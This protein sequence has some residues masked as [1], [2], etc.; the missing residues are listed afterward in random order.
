MRQVVRDGHALG[1]FAE[2]TR[3]QRRARRGAAGRGD[4]RDPGG[5]PSCP[6]PSTARRPGGRA[7]SI[8]CRSPGA[9]R[10]ASTGCRRAGG[11]PRG[12]GRAA[13]AGSA[14]S[15][16][17]SW[18]CTRSA[19]RGARRPTLCRHERGAEDELDGTVAI[20]GFPNVG[21]S[22]LVNRLTETRA[23]VVHE[24]PGVTRD[25]KELLADWN[26]VQLPDRRHRW[27]RPGRRGRVRPASRRA[28]ARGDRGGRPRA[29]RRRRA[30][31]ITPGRRGVADILRAPAS[32]CSSSRTRSTTRAATPRRS[33]ST[34]SGSATRCRSRRC[35]AT[36]RAT[37]STRSSSC[38]PAR[39]R[40]PV[41]EEAIRVAILG[42]PNVGKSSLLNAL[43]GEERVIV[44]EVP[45]TTR[46]AIDTVLDRRRRDVRARRHRGPAPQAAAA[47]ASSTTR[48]CAR[49]RRPSVRTC[50]R[51]RRRERGHRRAGPSRRGRGPQGTA[52]RRSSC[53]P[54][55]TSASLESRRRAASQRRGYASARR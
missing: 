22:T 45:G 9:S 47:R 14:C 35:T 55:G 16:S 33:S 52:R 11:L 43:V 19:G 3:Q 1:L 51:A 20:V 46:D 42:R 25:R 8:R 36:G 49:C 54:S 24:T 53:S 2:G 40:P 17:G 15:G 27:R 48:S 50:A 21:K 29:L 23:A 38:F 4:G 5:C 6:P 28:G 31:G 32:R 44:S 7:T 26:G 30:R 10:S 37:C 12:L 13:A 18:R 39:A 34:A 41:G